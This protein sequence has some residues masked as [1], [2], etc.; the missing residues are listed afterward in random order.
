MFAGCFGAVM[1]ANAVGGA[2]WMFKRAHLPAV[3]TMAF[4]AVIAAGYMLGRFAR[5]FLIIVTAN[6]TAT[7][8]VMIN[9]GDHCPG[10][11][12]MAGITGAGG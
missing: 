11:I 4:A 5:H 2:W 3:S 10:A 12:Y 8:I 1:A 9:F 7:H 6:A